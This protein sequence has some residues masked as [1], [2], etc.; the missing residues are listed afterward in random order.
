[1]DFSIST[2][3]INQAI[4]MPTLGC[5]HLIDNKLNKNHDKHPLIHLFECYTKRPMLSSKILRKRALS[6]GRFELTPGVCYLSFQE[7]EGQNA[8]C[9]IF[10][11]PRGQCPGRSG[12][13]FSGTSGLVRGRFPD[14]HPDGAGRFPETSDQRRTGEVRPFLLADAGPPG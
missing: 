14:P 2:S 6:R 5:M 3:S 11:P 8:C 12:K 7:D 10:A 9:R 1:M 13:A 4:S